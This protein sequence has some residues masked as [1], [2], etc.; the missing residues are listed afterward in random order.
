MLTAIFYLLIYNGLLD[1]N[2]PR[3][4]HQPPQR[5]Q[6]GLEGR[7][8]VIDLQSSPSFSV[9]FPFNQFKVHIDESDI[10]AFYITLPHVVRKVFGR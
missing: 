4:L 7:L 9:N 3:L 6:E 10:P 5:G 2:I 8:V 1:K